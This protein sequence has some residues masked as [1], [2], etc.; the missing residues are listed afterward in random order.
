MLGCINKRLEENGET[1]VLFADNLSTHKCGDSLDFFKNELTS[2]AQPRFYPANL[3]MVVQPVDRHI[4]IIYKRA[5]YKA[6][7][8]EMNTR[9]SEH[10]KKGKAEKETPKHFTFNIVP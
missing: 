10:L 5:I 1:G 9:L 7:R 3:T 4:G 6:Y 8:S 2:F